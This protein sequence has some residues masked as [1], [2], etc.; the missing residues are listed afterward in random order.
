MRHR[1]FG[2]KL[3]RDYNARKA[4]LKNLVSSLILH[5]SIE[6]TEAK[7]KAIRGLVDKL[8]TKAK[9]KT[10]SDRRLIAS[11]LPSKDVVNKLVDEIAPK[12]AGRQGG[13]TRILKLGKR[14][15]DRAAIV[16]MEF[17]EKVEPGFFK[18][19]KEKMVA[20]K[21]EKTQAKTSTKKKT[22][23]LPQ[24]KKETKKPKNKRNESK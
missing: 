6:T 9:L 4:L 24:P 7:A 23:T 2:R 3:N 12:F 22:Q 1:V 5:G 20:P 15:G 10:L 14:M 21:I 19:V 11:F 17:V 18:P 13:F 16:K 8:V